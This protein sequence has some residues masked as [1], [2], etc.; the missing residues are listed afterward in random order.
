MPLPPLLLLLPLLAAALRMPLKPAKAGHGIELV[1]VQLELLGNQG[2]AGDFAAFHRTQTMYDDWM[3]PPNDRGWL[4]P[5]SSWPGV[6]QWHWPPQFAK[7]TP[8]TDTMVTDG[9]LGGWNNGTPG[10]RPK[11]NPPDPSN[12]VAY[13]GD[14]GSLQYRWALLDARLDDMVNNG[15]MPLV[16]LGRVPWTLSRGW[17]ATVSQCTYGNAAPPANFSEWGEVVGAVAR[18]LLGRYGTGRVSR[19][20]F[21]VLTEPNQPDSFTGSVVDYEKM[22]DFAAAQIKRVLGDSAQIGP[23]NFCRYCAVSSAGSGWQDAGYV[24]GAHTQNYWR[25]PEAFMRHAANGTNWATGRPG[26]PLDFIAMSSYGIGAPGKEGYA[27]DGIIRASGALM[28][29]WRALLGPRRAH[30]RL[31]LHEFGCLINRHWRV[32]TEPG[33][34]GAAW[35]VASWQAALSSNITAAFHWGFDNFDIDVDMLESSAWAMAMAEGAVAAA[36]TAPAYV[37]SAGN[38]SGVLPPNTTVTAFA[39]RSGSGDGALWVFV[40]ALNAEKTSIAPLDIALRLKL[41]A[42]FLPAGSTAGRANL[43]VQQWEM[44]AAASPYDAALAQLQKLNATQWPDDEVYGF[45][46]MSTAAGLKSLRA[47][48]TAYQAMQAASMLPQAF[49]GLVTADAAAGTL[50]LDIA[51]VLSPSVLVLRVAAAADAAALALNAEP[52]RLR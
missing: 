51:S 28:S 18:H 22:Y 32:S 5:R 49:V 4:R 30:L 23:A 8:F 17:P 43:T 44:D 11:T 26:S 20:R 38:T 52:G 6:P 34:F 36:A 16:M 15:V 14:D 47:N 33:A 48:N 29:K 40:S 50:S 1:H 25:G 45:E 41:D 31:E 2:A 39:V 7:T 21:R 10:N 27:P 12:D 46:A 9:L 19:W 24:P 42:S 35:T 3:E 37:L 13:R